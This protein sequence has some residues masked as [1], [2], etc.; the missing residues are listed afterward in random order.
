MSLKAAVQLPEGRKLFYRQVAALSEGGVESGG[1]VSFAEDE[2]VTV[3]PLW[4]VRVVAEH[5]EVE[6]GENL[7]GGQ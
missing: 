2:A 4:V 3:R 5:F 1:G 7:N 6:G